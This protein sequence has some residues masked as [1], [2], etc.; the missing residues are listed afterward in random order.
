MYYQFVVYVLKN[1]IDVRIYLLKKDNFFWQDTNVWFFW[2]V[3]SLMATSTSNG[4][5]I[6]FTVI[7]EKF[8]K[9][10]LYSIG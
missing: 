7:V 5:P 8:A 9:S 2:Y 10:Y 6:L 3:V 1:H 4:S